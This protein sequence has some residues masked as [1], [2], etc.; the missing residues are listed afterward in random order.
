MSTLTQAGRPTPG[1]AVPT[2]PKNTFLDYFGSLEEANRVIPFA[3]EYINRDAVSRRRMEKESV[4]SGSSA[5]RCSPSNLFTSLQI[6]RSSIFQ[7][8]FLGPRRPCIGKGI[9]EQG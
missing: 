8:H 2:R 5:L 6:R 9:G 1:F 4:L 3:H 7:H